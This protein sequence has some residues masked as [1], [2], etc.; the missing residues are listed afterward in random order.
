VYILKSCSDQQTE[1]FDAEISV[2]NGIV[3]ADSML[4]IY[5]QQNTI[6]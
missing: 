5:L 6:C 2:W 4:Y 1:R 3:L